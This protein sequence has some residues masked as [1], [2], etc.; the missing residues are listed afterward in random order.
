MNDIIR[1]NR[2]GYCRGRHGGTAARRHGS[3]AARSYGEFDPLGHNQH[4]GMVVWAC[5][6]ELTRPKARASRRIQAR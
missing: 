3:T 2:S 4:Q 1:D 6:L 5:L